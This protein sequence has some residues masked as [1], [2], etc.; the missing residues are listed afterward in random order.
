MKMKIKGKD[1]N[2]LEEGHGSCFLNIFIWRKGEAEMKSA[3]LI[4]Q[5]GREGPN[6]RVSSQRDEISVIFA[7]KFTDHF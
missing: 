5:L 7:Q 2:N 1:K 6:Q 4:L 3:S